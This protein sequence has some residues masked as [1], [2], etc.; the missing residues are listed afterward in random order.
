MRCH[1]DSSPDDKGFDFLVPISRRCWYPGR[2]A[3]QEPLGKGGMG[4][5]PLG[6]AA[7]NN[8][9][10]RGVVPRLALIVG[11]AGVFRQPTVT[12]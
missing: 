11:G 2:A 5:E 12:V 8:Q 10:E 4:L 6:K 9:G 3:G 7:T 1:S